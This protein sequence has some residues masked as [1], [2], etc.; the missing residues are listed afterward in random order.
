MT[1]TPVWVLVKLIQSVQ[2]IN[3]RGD[4]DSIGASSKGEGTL[5]SC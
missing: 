2:E 3:L 5:A 1:K 4:G